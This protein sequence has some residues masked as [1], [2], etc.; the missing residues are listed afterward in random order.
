MQKICVHSEVAEAEASS[1]LARVL[2]HGTP[3]SS[4]LSIE[5]LKACSAAASESEKLAEQLHALYEAAMETLSAQTREVR[6]QLR[7]GLA[8]VGICAIADIDNSWKPLG[9]CLGVNARPVDQGVL[10]EE[11]YMSKLFS[12]QLWLSFRRN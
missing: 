8:E 12:L 3:I 5:G 11:H 9:L 7:Y 2:R 10:K 4:L 1:A 6:H